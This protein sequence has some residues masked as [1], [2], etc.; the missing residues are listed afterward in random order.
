MEATLARVNR[1]LIV[2]PCTYWRSQNGERLL[3]FS[4]LRLVNGAAT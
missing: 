2:C 3:R 4:K 1:G